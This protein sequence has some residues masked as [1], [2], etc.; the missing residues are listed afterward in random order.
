MWNEAMPRMSRREHRGAMSAIS[1]GLR[2]AATTP[3]VTMKTGNDPG[4][5]RSVRLSGWLAPF[6]GAPRFG[7]EPGVSLALNPRLMAGKPPACWNRALFNLN[8]FVYVE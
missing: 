2:S 6:Q 1:R 4:R 3:P 5:G 8:E 7:L